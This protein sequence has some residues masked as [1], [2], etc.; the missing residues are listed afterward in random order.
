MKKLMLL[1]L[2]LFF[3]S[4]KSKKAISDVKE[5]N[6][7]ET[8]EGTITILKPAEIAEFPSLFLLTFSSFI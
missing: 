3:T 4:C 2:I 6:S 7:K 8:T 5:D 1:G